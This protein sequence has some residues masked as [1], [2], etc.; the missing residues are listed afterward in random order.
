MN[1]EILNDGAINIDRNKGMVYL[2]LGTE[3]L[4]K[5]DAAGIVEIFANIKLR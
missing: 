4:P 2:E 3:E 5:K 1:N